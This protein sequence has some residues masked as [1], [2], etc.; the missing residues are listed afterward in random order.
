[1]TTLNNYDDQRQATDSLHQWLAFPCTSSILDN[2]GFKHLKVVYYSWNYEFY[3][4]GLF[5]SE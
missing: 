2:F 1:M 3:E 4:E 5:C